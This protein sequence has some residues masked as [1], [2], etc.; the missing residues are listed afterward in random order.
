MLFKRR[1]K[2]LKPPAFSRILVRLVGPGGAGASAGGAGTAGPVIAG[3]AGA[4]AGDWAKI[5]VQWERKMSRRV[6]EKR[7]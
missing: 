2:R 7:G 5:L 3:A 4:A 1:I 6:S